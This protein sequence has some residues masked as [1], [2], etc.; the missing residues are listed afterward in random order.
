MKVSSF[1]RNEFNSGLQM[2]QFNGLIFLFCGSTMLRDKLWRISLK[3]YGVIFIYMLRN[4][5]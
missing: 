5:N 1:L 3:G 4:S 2:G